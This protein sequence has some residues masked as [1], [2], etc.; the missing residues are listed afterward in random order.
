MTNQMWFN[1][2]C[3]FV[4]ALV[5]GWAIYCLVEVVLTLAALSFLG[6]VVWLIWGRNN[7]TKKPE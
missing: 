6:F 2:A 3:L 7:E 4:G 1:A 5:L